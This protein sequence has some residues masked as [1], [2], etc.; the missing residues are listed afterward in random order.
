MRRISTLPIVLLAAVLSLAMT[1]M[2]AEL[3]LVQKAGALSPR[4]ELARS[5]VARG[6]VEL[7][8]AHKVWRRSADTME[9]RS[10]LFFIWRAD[11]KTVQITKSSRPLS[12]LEKIDVVKPP[13]V[14]NLKRGNS[15]LKRSGRSNKR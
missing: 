1:T 11:A 7:K 4:K 9:K 15:L 13:T 12:G 6:A 2:A 3:P 8:P 5:G 14:V 10:S